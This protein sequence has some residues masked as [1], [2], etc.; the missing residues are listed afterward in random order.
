MDLRGMRWLV[1]AAAFAAGCTQVDENPAWNP[2]VDYPDWTYDAP[3]YYR[4][5][6]DLQVAETI[7]QGIPV[8][9]SRNDSFFI[10]HPGGCQVNGEP[11]VVVWSSSHQGKDWTKAGCFGVEQSHFLFKAD[12]DGP[13]WV[14]FVGPGQGISQVPPGMPHRIYVVDTKMPEIALTITPG[15]WTDEENK[16]PYV[17]RVGETVTLH[18]AVRDA[19]LAAGTIKLGT[20]FA[21]FPH[22]LVWS[23][24]PKPMPP[25]GSIKKVEIPPEA[26]RDGG[27]RFRME[28]AD[29]AGNVGMAM[30][31]VLQIAGQAPPT[32]P[33][34]RPAAEGDLVHQTDGTEPSR[35]GWPMPGSLLRGGT[36]CVLNWIPDL[37]SKYET[38]EL[39]FTADNGRS[40]RTVATGLT[41]G[42]GVKWT[43]PSVSSKNCRLRLVALVKTDEKVMLAMTQEFTVDTIAPDTILG[44]QPIEP[45]GGK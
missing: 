11:R 6:E 22:N 38:I 43:V 42:W 2:Q 18:W 5:T 21:K 4:P 13:Q 3:F 28:A 1:L 39:Q 33:I 16:V 19:N 24:F 45:D 15:P 37:A 27:M 14:R 30:T 25:T 31:E 20:C 8:Y 12:A 10:R 17:Y 32:Q 23:Q 29:R 26:V 44:P 35:P 36:S 40:W 34:A 7:G 9:Y 41:P